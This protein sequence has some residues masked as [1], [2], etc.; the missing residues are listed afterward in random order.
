MTDSVRICKKP[1]CY[2][3]LKYMRDDADYCCTPHRVSVTGNKARSKRRSRMS[4]EAERNLGTVLLKML[5]DQPIS[6]SDRMY[7]KK[8]GLSLLK[9][10]ERK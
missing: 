4:G 5:A 3:S 7:V 9:A 6:A 2:R 8:F 10:G 1:K